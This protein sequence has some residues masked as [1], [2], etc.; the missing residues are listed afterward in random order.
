MDNQREHF[1]R[2]LGGVEKRVS[3]GGKRVEENEKG[4]EDISIAEIKR[5]IRKLKDEKAVRIDGIPGEAWK[6]GGVEMEK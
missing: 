3:G 5:A 1:I 2:V 4:E 6:Y